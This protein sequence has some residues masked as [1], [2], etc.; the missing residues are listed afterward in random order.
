M[1]PKIEI[2]EPPNFALI[3]AVFPE[4]VKPGV[5]FA[6]GD[7]IFNPSGVEI[8]PALIAHECTHLE[9]QTG[10]VPERLNP[11]I[12][13]DR[14]LRDPEFR[15]DEELYAH[16]AEFEAQLEGFIDRNQRAQLLMRTARRLIAP[17][18]QYPTTFTLQLAM[19]DIERAYR[20]A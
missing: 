12:W 15:Y 11:I 9:R 13:W 7:T 6:Y 5:I 17:L 4:A 3:V 10:Y 14:Y 1:T 8:P 19:R 16:V 18:Y 20:G 2:A